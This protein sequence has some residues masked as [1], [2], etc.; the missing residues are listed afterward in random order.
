MR[1]G[2]VKVAYI[3]E[4]FLDAEGVLVQALKEIKVVFNDHFVDR[5]LVQII[6]P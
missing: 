3:F 6:P 1:P 2:V 5:S 4:V